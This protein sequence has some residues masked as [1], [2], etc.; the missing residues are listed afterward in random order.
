M[1]LLSEGVRIAGSGLQCRV[2]SL[3]LCKVTGTVA[4]RGEGVFPYIYIYNFYLL[5]FLLLLTFY[6]QVPALFGIDTRMLT[7]IIRDKVSIYATLKYAQFALNTFQRFL[8]FSSNKGTVLGKIE[9]D[10]QP[11]EITDP[12]QRNLVAEVSTKVTSILD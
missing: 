2:Q 11:V 8:F 3:E 7:K 5:I 9:F 6:F 12:N 4:S 1:Y 10:G